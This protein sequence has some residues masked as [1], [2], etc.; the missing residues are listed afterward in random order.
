M[1]FLKQVCYTLPDYSFGD[2]RFLY[3]R[4]RKK[5][6]GYLKKTYQK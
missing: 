5:R 3:L 1:D 6:P 4:S 2:L